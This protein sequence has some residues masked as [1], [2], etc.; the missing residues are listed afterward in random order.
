M[1]NPT[2]DAVEV[3]RSKVLDFAFA[4]MPPIDWI[5]CD[6]RRFADA[7]ATPPV[8]P[9]NSLREA[10]LPANNVDD[11]GISDAFANAGLLDGYARD[12]AREG[13]P[14]TADTLRRAAA[15]V[16][17][18]DRLTATPSPDV[19]PDHI[20]NAGNMVPADVAALEERIAA[21]IAFAKKDSEHRE[22][23]E[24]FGYWIE[25]RGAE[26]ALLR[27]PAYIPE[28]SDLR[29]VTP[30]YAHPA[31]LSSPDVA[32]LVERLRS[33]ARCRLSF[34]EE[35]CDLHT[36][37]AD[38][39]ERLSSTTAPATDREAALDAERFR[40]LMRCGRIKMQGSA[41]FD[42]KT[43]E[44]KY[45]DRPGSVHF[46]AEFWPLP[47]RDPATGI[48]KVYDDCPRNITEWGHHALRALADDI[49]AC[50]AAA[51]SNPSDMRA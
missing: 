31:P 21:T 24:P 16:R 13:L 51:L 34:I 38:A 50:E 33:G 19:A 3:I 1:T 29:R 12:R 26:P 37:A 18:Y 47:A 23:L 46:G 17:G 22:R 6:W 41:G 2:P 43:G 8:M 30:L 45:P 35:H 39:L 40:A 10:S 9:D 44:R 20:A 7:F 42:P 36:G 27:K 48:V 49:L 4:N 32:A 11:Q 28:P 14:E 15:F 5:E 25:Q